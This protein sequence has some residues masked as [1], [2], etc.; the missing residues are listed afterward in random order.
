MGEA[1][2]DNKLAG[3][4]IIYCSSLT[5]ALDAA[6]EGGLQANLGKAKKKKAPG[7][8]KGRQ[9]AEEGS[10]YGT[11]PG[12]MGARDSDGYEYVNVLDQ[13]K[14]SKSS[15]SETE[16]EEVVLLDNIDEEYQ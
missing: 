12:E 2:V 1:S 11:L 8:G 9:R 16:D 5:E 13:L 4:D 7:A 10:G 6:L 15:L 14:R 3:C